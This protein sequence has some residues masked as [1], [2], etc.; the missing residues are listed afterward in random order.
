MN[1]TVPSGN[2]TKNSL[3]RLITELLICIILP[4]LILKKLSGSEHLGVSYS[5][6]FALS[7]P[8]AFALYRFQTERKFGLVPILGFISILLTGT[9]GLLKLDAQYIAIKEAAIPFTIG[10][11]TLISLKTP[12]P[13]V[14]TFLY[15]DMV[16]QVDKI[17]AALVQH[18]NQMQFEKVLVNATY[19]LAFSFL[20]STILNYIL[21]KILVT[22]Q[23]GTEEFNNQ[24]GTMTLLSY[25][26]IVIP[27]MIIM[28]YA[29]YYLFKQIKLL[30][31]LDLENILKQAQS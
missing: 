3:P 15:N 4:T 2:Q 10:V 26:V 14:K 16:M 7:L 23:S 21:A 29:M 8:L 22:A 28:I 13:L 31:H 9:I 17:E 24:L 18:N 19:L 5:L 25:P 1:S 27:S 20:L 11:F 30:T 12:Y 6:I